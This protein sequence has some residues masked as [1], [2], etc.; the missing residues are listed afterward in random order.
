MNKLVGAVAA[1]VVALA[2]GVYVARDYVPF[3]G[4]IFGTSAT[5]TTTGATGTS[6]AGN[7]TSGANRVT[8]P[9]V[10]DTD[11]PD[12]AFRRLETETGQETPEACLVFTRNLV[13]DGSVRY[14]DYL[15]FEPQADMA[16]RAAKALEADIIG[17]DFIYSTNKQRYLIV[18]ENTYPGIYPDCFEK[19]GKTLPELVARMALDT[20]KAA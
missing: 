7:D 10:A 8:V 12:F 14:E 5:T 6:T 11:L 17:F 15:R 20:L 18:D 13:A 1:G 19:A 2:A 9:P 3:L 16:L 4:D